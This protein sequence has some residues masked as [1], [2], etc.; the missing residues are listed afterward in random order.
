M[1]LE[2]VELRA[3][4][5]AA[6][7][8][9]RPEFDARGGTLQPLD[10]DL[11]AV[12]VRADAAALEQLFLNLLLNA[13]QALALGGTTTATL[14][15]VD[16]HAEVSI[17]DTG[18]GIEAERLATIFEPLASTRPGGTG[19][20]LTIARRIAEAHGGRIDIESTRGEGTTVRVTLPCL[21]EECRLPA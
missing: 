13:A 20:G 3:P 12:F 18:R 19:L 6:W 15:R 16:G 11:P 21:L 2:P 4:L 5:Q 10:P 9:A 17:R 14:S 8:S 7:Q 1:A